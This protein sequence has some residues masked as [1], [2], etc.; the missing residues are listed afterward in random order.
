VLGRHAHRIALGAV[1]KAVAHALEPIAKR[2]SLDTLGVGHRGRLEAHVLGEAQDAELVP[3]VGAREAGVL[4]LRLRALGHDG[5]ALPEVA[6][7]EDDDAAKE[8]LAGSHVLE[9][10]VDRLGAVAM[11]HRRL[12][13]DDEHGAAEEL[14]ELGLFGHA[15]RGFGEEL[16]RDVETRMSCQQR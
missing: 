1:V 11:L 10:A 14:G 7:E 6:A 5:Q 3:D 12:V 4:Y 9:H 2:E 15:Q 8:L 13:P 16:N